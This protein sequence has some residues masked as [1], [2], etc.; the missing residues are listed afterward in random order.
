MR[1]LLKALRI[2]SVCQEKRTVH[3]VGHAQND[4]IEFPDKA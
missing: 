4:W 3:L 2:S 1:E